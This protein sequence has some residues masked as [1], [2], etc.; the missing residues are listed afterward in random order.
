MSDDANTSIAHFTYKRC[1]YCYTHLKLNATH[2]IE[3][4]QKVGLV[5]KFGLAKKP[6]NYKAYLAALLWVVM[7]A[8]YTWKVLIGNLLAQLTK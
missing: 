8:I 1:P 6:F 7:L 5:D 2:C 4:R 3:C